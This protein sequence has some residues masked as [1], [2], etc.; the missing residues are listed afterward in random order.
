MTDPIADMLTR[1]R[2]AQA[3]NKKTVA[4][5]MSKLKYNI[6]KILERGGWIEK[7]EVIKPAAKKNSSAAFNEMK[8][9]LKYKNGRPAISCLKKISTPGRRVYAGKTELPKVLNNMGIAII[10]TSNG[11]MTNQEAKRQ[12]LGGEVICEIY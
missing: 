11:L 7:V 6:A 12:G 5:P 2:N 3:V 4:L 9:E 8:I 1:I 10:S